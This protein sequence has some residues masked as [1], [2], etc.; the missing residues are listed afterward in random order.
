MT[1]EAFSLTTRLNST[2]KWRW[3]VTIVS[4]NAKLHLL[5]DGYMRHI[6]RTFMLSISTSSARISANSSSFHIEMS[7]TRSSDNEQ[8]KSNRLHAAYRPTA[9]QR[10]G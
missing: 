5:Y 3:Q 8:T 6:I 9:A 7:N 4:H 1:S 10:N 2:A